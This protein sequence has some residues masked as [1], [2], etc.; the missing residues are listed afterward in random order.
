[1]R[2]ARPSRSGPEPIE[3]KLFDWPGSLSHKKN[4]EFCDQMPDNPSYTRKIIT[5]VPLLLEIQKARGAGKKIILTNGC[6]DILHSGHV[7]YLQ[8]ARN[9]LPADQGVLIT[10]VN[11]DNSVRRL[12]GPW[13]PILPEDQRLE[14]VAAL[15]CTDWVILFEQSDVSALIAE[16]RPD[17]HAK[18]TDY[19]EA[20]VPER[21]LVLRFGGQVRIVGDAKNHSTR[22]LIALVRQKYPAGPV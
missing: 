8:G 16:I 2:V 10:A 17:F 14:L 13:R 6:F 9:I 19:T 18:G 3:R 11:S 4:M 5:L 12:K 22:D 1:M 15:Y 7:R 21:E 20:T